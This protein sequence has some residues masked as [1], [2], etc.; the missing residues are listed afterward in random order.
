M[1][2][3]QQKP[4]AFTERELQYLIDCVQRD[5]RGL[6]SVAVVQEK[7]K[8]MLLAVSPYIPCKTNHVW[9]ERATDKYLWE[10][11]AGIFDYKRYDTEAAAAKALSA[12]VKH[13]HSHA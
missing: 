6:P 3:A 4:A 1:T 13:L 2:E 12:Y 10:D 9:H 8:A 7:L 11:E 5:P